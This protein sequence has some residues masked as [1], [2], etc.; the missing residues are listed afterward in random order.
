MLKVPV[1]FRSKD[2]ARGRGAGRINGSTKMG[3]KFVAVAQRPTKTHYTS[4]HFVASGTQEHGV[5][6][7]VEKLIF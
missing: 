7:E 6:G 1:E 2:G 3:R 4:K 5:G